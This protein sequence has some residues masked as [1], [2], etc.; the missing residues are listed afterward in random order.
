[1]NKHLFKLFFELLNLPS[2]KISFRDSNEKS[3]ENYITTYKLF[4]KKHRLKIIRNKVIGV[5]IIDLN[6]FN[7]YNEYYK[8]I[9]GKNSAA[10]YSRKAKKRD[11]NF[12]EIDRNN[13]IENIYEINTSKEI[14]QG[15]KMSSKYQNKTKKYINK[16]NYKYFGIVKGEEN[17]VSY[18]NIGFFGE[19]AVVNSLLGHS[20]HLNN[21]V[22]YY[23]MVEFHKIMIEEYKD[24]GYRYIMYDTFYGGSVGLR[25]FK[26]KLGYSPYNVKWVWDV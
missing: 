3:I 20:N 7:N 16:N 25:K 12:L 1:M 6:N 19:F 11:Y 13:Y 15:R 9:N 10:Y 8:S 18:C 5:S 2:I 4:T 17:L 26:T 24:I 22:M 21:G 14:R 23:M